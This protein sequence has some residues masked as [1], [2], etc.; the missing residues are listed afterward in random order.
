MDVLV[1]TPIWIDYFRGGESCKEMDFLIDE[2]LIVTNELILAE[3]VP[4]LKPESVGLGRM[5]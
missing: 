4:Y 5:K 2:N 3:L 1:D